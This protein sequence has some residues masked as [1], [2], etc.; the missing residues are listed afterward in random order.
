M[1]NNIFCTSTCQFFYKG[2]IGIFFFSNH[3]N[4]T[5]TGVEIAKRRVL[6]SW[7]ILI[8]T[9]TVP[10]QPTLLTLFKCTLKG[11]IYHLIFISCEGV[12]K[13]WLELIPA[14]YTVATAPNE[15]LYYNCNILAADRSLII[16]HILDREIVSPGGCIVSVTMQLLSGV[17]CYRSS[18]HNSIVLSLV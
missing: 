7:K 4:V 10:F 14:L 1:L 6:T 17:L 16:L 9:G 12:L 2:N 11:R 5:S 8:T 15:P 13:R 3:L 18:S